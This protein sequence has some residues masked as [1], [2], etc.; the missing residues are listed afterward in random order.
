[1]P[2]VGLVGGGE[3]F[4][5]KRLRL[6]VKFASFAVKLGNNRFERS[7]GLQEFQAL[8]NQRGHRPG[9][10]FLHLAGGPVVEFLANS[11]SYRMTR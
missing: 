1:M 3:S 8:A 2:A 7:A 5:Q 6:A 9:A 11:G 10:A 4:G